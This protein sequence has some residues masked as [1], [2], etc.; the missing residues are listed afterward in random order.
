MSSDGTI[1]IRKL[2][3]DLYSSQLTTHSR[4]IIGFSVVIFTLSAFF[5]K[6]LP[7]YDIA[8][9]VIFLSVWLVSGIFWY[10]LM[11]HITYGI[12]SQSVLEVDLT[13]DIKVL[14]AIKKV[15]DYTFEKRKIFGIFPTCWFISSG[16]K[17]TRTH[18]MLGLKISPYLG[19]AICVLL[20]LFTAIIIILFLYNI[21]LTA[22]QIG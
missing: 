5:G 15:R 9:I 22:T 12:L 19:P 1:H 8:K 3:L 11:R 20:G 16:K 4:L 18:K 17:I 13:E 2:L 10:L 21:S 14:D 7:N 6:D